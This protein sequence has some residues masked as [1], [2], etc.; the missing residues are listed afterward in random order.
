MPANRDAVLAQW[1]TPAQEAAFRGLPNHDQAHLLRV[2]RALI[3][4]GVTDPDLL[5]A[6]LLHDLGKTSS[7]GRVR[8]S[9]RVIKVVLGRIR[10]GLLVRFARTPAPWYCHGVWLAIHHASL[11]AERAAAL[12]CTPR[13]CWLIAHH[14]DAQPAPDAALELLMEIDRETV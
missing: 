10:P 7:R 13:T 9:D 14:E 11:G 1:L 5:V 2:H 3:A 4:R 8:F 6:G 12:G